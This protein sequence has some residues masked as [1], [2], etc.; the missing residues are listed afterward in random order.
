MISRGPRGR[1]RSGDIPPGRIFAANACED[2]GAG[3]A[4]DEHRRPR[5]SGRCTLRVVRSEENPMA[6]RD[7]IDRR[8]FLASAAAGMALTIVPRHVLGGREHRPQ[9]QAHPG[10]H[11]VRHAGNPRDAEAPP[12]AG[13]PDHGRVRSRQ[14]RHEL[15]RLGQ[16]RDP[17]QR[18]GASA[19]PRL[20]RRS[21]RHPRRP[22]HGEGD[23][24][25]LLCETAGVGELQERGE[26]RRLQGAPGEGEGPRQREDHDAR[27][28][29]RHD[30]HRR[31]EEAQA[32]G[33]AQAPGEPGGGGPDGGGGGSPVG[34]RHRPAGLAPADHGGPGDD[35]GRRHRHPEGGA[36]LD[37]PA[38]LAPGARA[39]HRSAAGSAGV[40]LEPVAGAGA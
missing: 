37:R 4:V 38:L 6:P 31:H 27:P 3:Q 39:A 15:R 25:D 24:R 9:R 14:G 32:R 21:R 35:P 36:Q 22:G 19:A 28:P 30:L 2:T 23:H 26:L 11:R 29:A 7:D 8:E 33:R 40:R 16:D 1:A 12:P 10:V 34:G 20:G 18:A 17:R 13:R 5:T